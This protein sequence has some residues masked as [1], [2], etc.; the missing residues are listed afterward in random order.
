MR[1][2]SGSDAKAFGKKSKAGPPTQAVPKPGTLI[3]QNWDILQSSPGRPVTLVGCTGSI[4]NQLRHLT[5]FYGLDIRLVRQGSSRVGRLS[6]YV[7]AGEWFGRVYVD[8][9]AEHLTPP[10]SER[11]A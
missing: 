1:C 6:T 11:A 8:Y 2:F 10:A 4:N 7:L 5:D 9:I 3:R